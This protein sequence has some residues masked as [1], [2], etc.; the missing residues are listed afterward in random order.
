[1]A[2]RAMR[3]R[4][5]VLFAG[6]YRYTGFERELIQSFLDYGCDL[7]IP[8]VNDLPIILEKLG[9]KNLENREDFQKDQRD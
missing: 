8:T 6:V 9:G 7:I 4:G 5:K 3:V 1:M 2:S